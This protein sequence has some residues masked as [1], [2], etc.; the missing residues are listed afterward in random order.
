M[1]DYPL[2]RG[3][4]PDSWQEVYFARALDKYKLPYYFQYVINERRG[5][6]GA[7]IVDFVV[8]SPFYQP[9]E[10]FGRY[11]HEGELGAD[12]RMKLILE[13]NYFNRETIVIWSDELP[14]QDA[15]DMYVKQNFA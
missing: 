14:D 15:A 5:I 12:D 9:V 4:Y 10:I 6:R 3:Q 13:Q 7:I 8:T 1:P 11:W 2:I